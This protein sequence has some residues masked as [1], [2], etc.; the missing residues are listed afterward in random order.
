MSTA[1]T[2]M[3]KHVSNAM[4][5]SRI[6][7][8]N[9]VAGLCE[10]VGA[11]VE[12]VR[13]GMAADHRIGAQFLFPGL[14]FGGSC[15][16][17]DLA[18]LAHVGRQEGR[19]MHISEA[20]ARVN[21]EA[22]ERFLAHIVEHFGGSLAGRTIAFW[23][24]AFKPRTDDVREAPA[25]WLINSM[26]AAWPDVVIRAHDP[27]AIVARRRPL[28]ASGVLEDLLRDTCRRGRTRHLHG[29]ERVPH[30]GFRAHEGSHEER[31]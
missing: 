6:S 5:A 27:V 17:K 18:S 22:R 7:F 20:A 2:E 30:A 26:L 23:G 13:R 19:R 21:Q 15:F 25:I 28:P 14:G 10:V 1:S 16:P 3:T 12:E 11:D 31:P 4:L 24:L 9:E 8:I 29:V